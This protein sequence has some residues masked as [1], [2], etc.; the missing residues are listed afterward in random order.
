MMLNSPSPKPSYEIR[1]PLSL[2]AT[3]VA[4]CLFCVPAASFAMS[5]AL[6]VPYTRPDPVS[7]VFGDPNRGPEPSPDHAEDPLPEYDEERVRATVNQGNPFEDYGHFRLKRAAVETPWAVEAGSGSTQVD[8]ILLQQMFDRFDR[9]RDWKDGSLLRYTLLRPPSSAEMPEDGWPLVIVNPGVGAVGSQGGTPPSSVTQ[10]ESIIWAS[11]YH[12]SHYPAYV[13][14]WHPQE[15]ATAPP[16]TSNAGPSYPP[17]LEMLDDFLETHPVDRNR[18]Y[19][20]GFSMG[21]A[22]TWRFL[23]DRPD[24]YAAVVPHA[25]A[26]SINIEDLTAVRT[27]PIWMIVGNQDPWTGS[28]GNIRTY[29]ALLDAG[30]ERIRFWE[31]QDLGHH[32]HGLRSFFLPEWLF[33]NSLHDP[34]RAVAPTVL[35]HP[36]DAEVT[37]GGGI[38]LQANFMGAPAPAVQWRRDGVDLPGETGYFLRLSGVSLDEAGAYSVVAT[39]ASGSVETEAAQLRVFP[40]TTPPRLLSV[41]AAEATQ[42]SLIF[43]KPMEAGTGEF[44][45][46]NPANFSIT[47]ET[48][49]LSATLGDDARTVLLEV[50]ELQGN[51]S[52]SVHVAPL[53]DRAATP[54]ASTATQAAFTYVPGLAGHWKLDD[55]EGATALDSSGR[56]GHGALIDDPLWIEAG[57][58]GGAL[59]FDGGESR[60]SLPMDYLDTEQGTLA[61]WARRDGLGEQRRQTLFHKLDSGGP[62]SLLGLNLV[63]ASGF[64]IF[65]LGDQT[66]ILSGFNLGEEWAHM[67]LVWDN[68]AYTAYVNGEPVAE[69]AHGAFEHAGGNLWLGNRPDLAHGFEG[70]I[71]DVRLYDKAL[72]P[73]AVA[74]LHAGRAPLERARILGL[75]AAPEGGGA[76][77]LLFHAEAGVRYHLE[78]STN[79]ADPG[80]WEPVP[81]QSITGTGQSATF[82]G[83]RPEGAA[84]GVFFRIGARQAEE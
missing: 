24:F 41:A 80:A 10:S 23:F 82:T 3:A 32:S 50:A 30:A 40:D 14:A 12:R 58:V 13:I 26:L 79:L 75:T 49:V 81:G 16:G 11:P 20:K 56:A 1:P 72:A 37:E 60:L 29:Q 6:P 73:E 5:G 4:V 25:G 19:V 7:E 8:S 31:V 59:A 9:P 67:A 61:L 15:R 74:A 76:L 70:A 69:G 63:Q 55:G 51:V 39:N 2:A 54:N 71:D 77:S 68:G 38:T 52:Y 44:G 17:M 43:D 42:V 65:S 62:A 18:I 78:R 53:H 21:G 22:T 45:A 84:G 35:T 57:R 27:V 34:Q 46:E 36:A 28:A 33:S 83:E 47:P 48:P 66:S 64:L